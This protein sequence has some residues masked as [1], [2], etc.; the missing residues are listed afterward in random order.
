VQA[1]LDGEVGGNKLMPRRPMKFR[2]PCLVLLG[3]GL[4]LLRLP[5]A[6]EDLA[7]GKVMATCIFNRLR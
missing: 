4:A 5:G 6:T 3:L 2:L 1:G 7:F